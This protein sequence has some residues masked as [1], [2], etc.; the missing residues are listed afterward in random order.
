MIDSKE[1]M[2]FVN[3]ISVMDRYNLNKKRIKLLFV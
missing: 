3:Q 2:G 1:I